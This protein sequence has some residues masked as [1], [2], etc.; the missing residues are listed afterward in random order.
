MHSNVGEDRGLS[1]QNAA[2]PPA[3]TYDVFGRALRSYVELPAPR[4]TGR[5]ADWDLVAGAEEDSA[6]EPDGA[7]TL[8]RQGGDVFEAR[9]FARF[10]FSGRRIEVR[11]ARGLIPADLRGAITG[12][13]TALL[14]A[15][16]GRLVLH[17]T[18][19]RRGGR[20]VLIGGPAGTGKSTQS[21]F[22]AE[23]G[24][25]LHADDV[26]PLEWQNGKPTIYPGYDVIRLFPDAIQLIGR[27]PEDFPRL[28][29]QTRK[30][31][32]T[33]GSP[34][35]DAGQ[36][37]GIAGIV[38]LEVGDRFGLRQLSEREAVVALLNLLHPTAAGVVDSSAD[39]RAAAFGRCAELARQ[40]PVV[41]VCRAKTAE[42]LGRVAEAIAAQWAF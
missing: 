24:W 42:N 3:A 25:T 34:R 16:D 38:L 23:H 22:L 5:P 14:L 17:A 37:V 41:S 28:H 35:A 8:T 32:A 29:S 2:T 13:L 9:G 30:R 36:A 6:G 40:V 11:S 18:T 1:V 4:V 39:A 20:A 15:R 31:F 12:T 19:L 26:A 21:A 33:L 27:N 10:E 7:E